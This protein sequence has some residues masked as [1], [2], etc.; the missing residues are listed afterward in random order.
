MTDTIFDTPESLSFIIFTNSGNSIQIQ[1]KLGRWYLEDWINE[2]Y[3]STKASFLTLPPNYVVWLWDNDQENSSEY[4]KVGVGSYYNL[5]GALPK[6]SKGGK[7]WI[8]DV[9]ISDFLNTSQK[10]VIEIQRYNINT[11]VTNCIYSFTTPSLPPLPPT[12][13]NRGGVSIQVCGTDKSLIPPIIGMYNNESLRVRKNPITGK[14]VYPYTG[15][16]YSPAI[17][18][19]TPYTPP[20]T[21]PAPP[22]NNGNVWLVIGLVVFVLILL[23]FII[24]YLN[25]RTDPH[26]PPQRK[27]IRTY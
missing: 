19:P 25:M 1:A 15:I 8:T 4:K 20:P 13:V 21:P 2:K 27:V 5:N 23:V 14:L 10:A 24:G 3:D 6:P 22:S 7:V 12:T 9:D 11:F 26:P 18:L 16:G 17:P